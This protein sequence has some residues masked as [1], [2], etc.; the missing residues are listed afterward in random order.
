MS[1]SGPKAIPGKSSCLFSIWLFSVIL[2]NIYLPYQWRFS[3]EEPKN[4]IL[5]FYPGW[6]R[7]LMSSWY[8]VNPN[9]FLISTLTWHCKRIKSQCL[10]RREQHS[11]LPSLSRCHET[12]TS[13][14][15]ICLAWYWSIRGLC[16]F[17]CSG[18]ASIHNLWQQQLSSHVWD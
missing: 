17:S 11:W 2:A 15:V 12:S 5:H 3:W 13:E 16:C 6:K 18:N 8:T 14:C 4:C 7:I 1:G 9:N 10:I